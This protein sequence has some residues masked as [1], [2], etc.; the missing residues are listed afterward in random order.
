METTTSPAPA[1]RGFLL[2]TTAVIGLGV[3]VV[4][5]VFTRESSSY[6]I[7]KTLHV[8]FS[9][10][11]IGGGVV[12]T[13]LGIKAE[14]SHD[15]TE[16]LWLARQGAWVS[17]RV[18]APSALIVLAMGILMMLEVDWGWDRFWIVF[19]LIGFATTF[20]IAIGFIMPQANKLNRL[21]DTVGPLAPE[22]QAAMSRILLLAKLDS[23]VLILVV[24]DM[25]VRPFST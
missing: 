2:V 16:K 24:I 6:L 12:L 19:G 18:F 11:W 9:V 20:A 21:M 1:G 25:M 3:V 14:L 17:Q 13:L 23:A 4:A 15:A 10:I 7:Y 8:L 5:V 22:S